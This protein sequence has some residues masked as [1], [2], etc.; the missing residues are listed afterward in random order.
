[1]GVLHVSEAYRGG[2]IGSRLLA[3]ASREVA[4]LGFSI[5]YLTSE[6]EGS[7]EKYGWKQEGEA[8]GIIGDAIKVFQK[9]SG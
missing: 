6:L 3:H 8:Y 4:E 1:L 9:R 7:Y 2:E 5:F